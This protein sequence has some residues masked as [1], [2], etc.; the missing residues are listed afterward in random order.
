MKLITFICLGMLCACGTT[1]DYTIEGEIKNLQGNLYLTIQN[2]QG[3]TDTLAVASIDE[4]N[5]RFEGNLSQDLYAALCAEGLKIPFFLEKAD[6]RMQIDAKNHKTAIITGGRLQSIRNE[7]AETEKE[8][9]LKRDS[10]NREY[11]RYIDENNIFGKMHIRAL[12]MNVDSI[13]ELREN[14]FIAQNN[15]MVSAVL[16]K[17]RVNE[18]LRR[19]MLPKK[20][21]LLGDSARN[22]VV[23]QQLTTYYKSQQ[24]TCIGAVAPDFTMETPEGKPI[25]LHSIKAKVKVVDF[26]AS[27]CGPCRAENPNVKRLYEKYKDAGLE[28]IGVSLDTKKEPWIKAIEK[29]G[30]TWI[31]MSD[32]RGW[33]SAA[34]KLFGITGI[35]Y[36]MILDE[37]NRILGE[38][39]YGDALENC[40]EKALN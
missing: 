10:L 39:L 14:Q 40:I 18:L 30:L 33:E 28:I 25:S 32:L 11:R 2:E 29:D 21:E 20:Y 19:K 16:V 34:T 38:K 26:W 13:Y 3:K 15:N 27:W 22:S 7:F 1:P 8:I 24:N 9:G 6:I 4:G 12:M 5:F 23:G 37:N 31:H 35:P 17:R 36:I